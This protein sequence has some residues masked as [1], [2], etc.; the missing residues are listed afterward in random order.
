MGDA[1]TLQLDYESPASPQR[2]HRV[3]INL[4]RV[5]YNWGHTGCAKHEIVL[6]Y[7]DVSA[8]PLACRC[9]ATGCWCVHA[10]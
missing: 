8:S 3:A 7:G 5:T 9:S 1:N 2:W 6:T 10:R 4:T